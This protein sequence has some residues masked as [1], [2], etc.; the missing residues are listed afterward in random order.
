MK[1]IIGLG[2]P[3][4]KYINTRHN[5]GF[6]IVDE[7]KKTNEFS[8][9]KKSTKF[10]AEFCK[11]ENL[12]EKI[13][14]AK[15]LTYMNN[16]GQTVKSLA[17]FYKIK[18]HDIWVVHDDIDLPLGKVRITQKASAAGHNGV[19]SIIDNLKTNEFVRFRIGI[20]SETK[21]II[22]A[23]KYVLQKFKTEEKSELEEII[24][25]TIQAI[26]TALLGGITEAQNEF[27]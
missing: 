25:F 13:I 21:K 4:K 15:P 20:A 1:L 19:Q 16:S 12:G 23:E 5:I 18:S 6:V 9:W 17:R 26:N 2:N 14:L 3:G 8:D 10:K 7:F 22:P 11:G 27:N 24:K